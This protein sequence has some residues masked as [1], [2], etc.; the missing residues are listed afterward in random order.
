MKIVE[1]IPQSG[2]NVLYRTT[3]YRKWYVIVWKIGSGFV[4]IAFLTAVLFTLL[5]DSTEK[6]IISILPIFAGNL[7]TKIIYWGLLP[8]AGAAWVVEDVA[9]TLIGEFILTNQRIWVRGSPHP[10]S[11]SS[12]PLENVDSIKSRRDAI[13]IRQKATKKIQV[14]MLTDGDLFV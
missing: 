9:C 10:W 12:T 4:G 1:F 6:T 7:L 8:L 13:F 14:H 3:P 11:Y 5:A 2:E